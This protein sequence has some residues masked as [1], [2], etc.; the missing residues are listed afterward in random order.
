M[1]QKTWNLFIA[2]V[3]LYF[4]TLHADH[5]HF[6]LGGFTLRWN[7]L[8]ALTLLAM[9]LIRLRDQIF[10]IPKWVAFPLLFIALS[11]IISCLLSSYPN[12]CSY[13][14]GWYGLTVLCYF[15]LPIWI[16][17]ALGFSSILSLYQAS[18]ICVGLYAALQL[19]LS[20]AGVHDPFV[21]QF[22]SKNLAR[23]NAFCFEP[24]FYALY[25]T[26]IIFLYNA[27]WITLKAS[28]SNWAILG[29]N[30]LYLISTSTSIILA[31]T[32]FFLILFCIPGVDRKR[33]F[34]CIFIFAACFM[35]LFLIF[36]AIMKHFFL[37]FFYHG[38]MTHHSF[39]E[40]WI[41]IENGWKIFLQN[42][43]FG[44]GLGGYPCYLMDAFLKGD[45]SFHY[46]TSYGLM[47]EANNPVK[48][49]EPM[50]VST[51]LLA[52]LGLFGLCAFCLLLYGLIIQVKRVGPSEKMNAYCW[53]VSL[54]VT[55][56]V[57]Q[58]NQGMFRTYIWV[59]LAMTYAYLEKLYERPSII[60]HSA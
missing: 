26:P 9:L 36:P 16:V 24:S 6:V 60:H 22:V 1:S 27:R 46:L 17:K 10:S 13:Y 39:Y 43:F 19:V 34:K 33:I 21:S 4:F 59:H 29:I 53:L 31:Y 42:P 23:P 2:L 37:K 48:I 5:L 35:C 25:M 49:F 44:V 8:I 50:N 11:M 57:L 30:L 58:F 28:S 14:V 51:E 54:L 52:S 3:F 56:L 45:R 40:R 47:S 20:I 41:G 12:R 15:L 7:N 32:A 18:F 55:L 38:F